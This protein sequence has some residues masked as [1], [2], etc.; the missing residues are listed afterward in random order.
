M[1]VRTVRYKR[2]G[3]AMAGAL[4]LGVILSGCGD[5]SG[6]D[7]ARSTTAIE[8]CGGQEQFPVPAERIFVNDGNMTSMLLQLGAQD[9]IAGVSDLE[10][11]RDVLSQVYG[12]DVVDALPVA[13]E[14][15]PT[16]EN[17][18]ARTP[19]V[20]VAG[21]N[22]GYKQE[23]GVTPDILRSKGIAPYIL[24]ESCRRD[25]GA[26]GIVPAWEALDTDLTNLGVL[27]GEEVTAKET[28]A[29]IDT[30]LAALA[31]APKGDKVPTVFLFDSGTNE[32]YT[33]G[34]YGG[35][36]AII[37]AAGARNATEDVQDT[38][39]G[40]SWERLV[41]SRP[42]FFAFVDYPPQTF[43]DK[44]NVLRTNPATKDLPAVKEGRFLNL[45]YATW[46]SGPLN[47]DAAENLRKALETANLLPESQ[48]APRH[49]LGLPLS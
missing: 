43:A 6:G 19:D 33:S 3:V 12:K 17:I 24:T 1:T 10:R 42:D 45:P 29:D 31:Q 48:I 28:M 14:S 41:A 2:T 4:A 38:W 34:S 40:V 32:I 15:Y 16:L 37:S 8:N 20:M 21:W 36:Q 30:R 22:Y 11:H 26:R 44:V 23:K 46:T 49:D 27:T 35:P 13:A 47:V 25:D 39:T 7:N 5:D 9:R 18:I